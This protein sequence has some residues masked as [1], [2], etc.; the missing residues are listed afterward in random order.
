LATDFLNHKIYHI[1]Y[2]IQG[3]KTL[4]WGH[5]IVIFDI[6]S[7]TLIKIQKAHTIFKILQTGN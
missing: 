6:L 5:Q 7:L 1:E 2:Q 4:V 3:L